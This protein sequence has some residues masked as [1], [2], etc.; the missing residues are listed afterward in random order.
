MS[1]ELMIADDHT[2]FIAGL[3]VLLQGEPFLQLLDEAGDGKQV[4]EILRQR[5]P[6]IVLLDIQMPPHHNGIEICRYIKQS[7][8]AVKV[9]MLTTYK[10]GHLIEAAKQNGAHGYLLKD[11]TKEELVETIVAVFQGAT[12]FPERTSKKRQSEG[13]T[14]EFL[15]QF[16]LSK[17]EKQ[18]LRLIKEG[19][20]NQQMA[21]KLYLSVFTIETHRKNCKQ[22]L[23][24]TK[25]ADLLKFLLE[26][27]I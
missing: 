11:C 19:H 8:P 25:P 24:L 17:R 9:I 1:I 7:Y 14:D 3:K 22:K 10:D 4:L 23:G 20:T 26:N 21:D 12:Y 16:Q 5:Q 13:E 2:L 27:D 6:H 18:I 15:K